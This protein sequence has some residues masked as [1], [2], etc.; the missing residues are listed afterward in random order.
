MIVEVQTLDRDKIFLASTKYIKMCWA[1]MMGISG[2]MK[3]P[4]E[5]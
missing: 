2:V 5:A 3:T 4:V 1:E